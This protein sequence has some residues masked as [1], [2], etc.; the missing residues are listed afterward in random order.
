MKE[1]KDVSDKNRNSLIEELHQE[2]LKEVRNMLAHKT[3]LDTFRTI[4]SYKSG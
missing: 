3:S 1:N 4:D 2:M